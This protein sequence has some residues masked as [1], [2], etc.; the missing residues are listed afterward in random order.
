MN[1]ILLALAGLAVLAAV[2]FAVL[3]PAP[4]AAGSDD[5]ALQ[6]RLTRMQY[7]V[8]QQDGTEPP[9][10]NAYWDNKAPGLYVDVVDGTPLFASTTKYES[11]TGWPSF[12]EPLSEDAVTTQPDHSLLMTRTEVRSPSSDSHLG[13]V[14]TDGP[15]PTG[16]R[17]CLNSAALRFVPADQLD[18]E[19]YGEY[20]DLFE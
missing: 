14:F 16:L 2:G 3:R 1:K 4:A 18:A 5:A 9:F 7:Y 8:T 12:W 13:H 6:D 11:G 17:Y 10:A 20:A 19:G 15:E